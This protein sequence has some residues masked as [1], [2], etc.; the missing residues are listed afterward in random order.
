M[1]FAVAKAKILKNEDTELLNLITHLETKL[2]N[3]DKEEILRYNELKSKWEYMQSAKT[4]GIILR[5]KA[6]IVEEGER[7]TKFFLNLEKYNYNK[8][9][10]KAVINH[11]GILVTKPQEVLMEQA[12]FY[13]KLYT[14]RQESASWLQK[15]DDKFTEKKIYLHLPSNKNQY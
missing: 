8:K 14:S 9:H 3:S 1:I 4:K 10:M 5:S 13:R 2:D 15:L 11:E 12:N 6:Q 7:N